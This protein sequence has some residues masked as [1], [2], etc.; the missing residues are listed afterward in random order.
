M[1]EKCVV[2][3]VPQEAW[4]TLQETLTLDSRSPAFDPSERERVRKA[5]ESVEDLGPGRLVPTVWSEAELDM[6]IQCLGRVAYREP[7][8][9]RSIAYV[10][11]LLSRMRSMRTQ[12]NAGLR[13]VIA[14]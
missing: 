4:D 8:D 9:A 13:P 1:P 14:K 3:Q 5:L 11:K 2:L 7:L 10:R 12:R 6:Q